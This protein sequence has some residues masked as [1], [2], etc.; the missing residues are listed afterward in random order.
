M[1]FFFISW[2]ERQLFKCLHSLK[3]FHNKKLQESDIKF[4]LWKMTALAACIHIRGLCVSQAKAFML[5]TCTMY[6]LN[7]R[8]TFYMWS[9]DPAIIIKVGFF[10]CCC[11]VKK[12]CSFSKSRVISLLLDKGTFNGSMLKTTLMVWWLGREDVWTF[13]HNLW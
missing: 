5:T 6:A 2:C 11:R 4:I 1:D 7:A 12:G 8:N 3:M 10:F 13:L 9:E